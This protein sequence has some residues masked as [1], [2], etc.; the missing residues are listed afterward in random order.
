[1][2]LQHKLRNFNIKHKLTLKMMSREYVILPRNMSVS[3]PLLFVIHILRHP[4]VQHSLALT[5]MNSQGSLEAHNILDKM[6]NG[7][8]PDPTI[9]AGFMINTRKH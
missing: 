3:L 9:L 2:P 5:L 7:K 6:L 8:V 1:M 4:T